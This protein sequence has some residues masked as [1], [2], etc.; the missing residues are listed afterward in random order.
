MTFSRNS[1]GAL[2][3]RPFSQRLSLPLRWR[4]PRTWSLATPTYSCLN[5]DVQLHRKKH[6][7]GYSQN[8]VHVFVVAVP[9]CVRKSG[10]CSCRKL[11]AS[12][13][14]WQ[15]STH[16]T[17]SQ[18]LHTSTRLSRCTFNFNQP[19]ALAFVFFASLEHVLCQQCFHGCRA[20]QSSS[21]FLKYACSPLA[22]CGRQWDSATNFFSGNFQRAPSRMTSSA[23]WKGY[24]LMDQILC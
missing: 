19:F 20:K 11:L 14:R 7:P 9:N 6:G 3:H 24:R 13:P 22:E 8:Q 1:W 4:I 21:T 16:P 12:F 10:G 2:F 23:T 17:S 18:G 5:F 15:I